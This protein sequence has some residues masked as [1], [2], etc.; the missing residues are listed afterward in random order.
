MGR[1]AP[2]F[3]ATD[4]NGHDVRLADYRGHPVLL[5]FWASWCVPCKAEFPLLQAGLSRHGDLRVVGVV[6]N[7]SAKSARSFMRSRQASWPGVADPGAK[8]ASAYHV[9]AK[10]GIPVSILVAPDGRVAARHLGPFTDAADLDR[11]LATPTPS[12]T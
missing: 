1:A 9:G 4:L 8:I 6:F 10:P 2:V 12:G 11:F 3:T 7:D 5:N